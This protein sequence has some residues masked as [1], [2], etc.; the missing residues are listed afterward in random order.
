MES[1]K[2]YLDRKSVEI[3]VWL[4]KKQFQFENNAEQT[5]VNDRNLKYLVDRFY[6]KHQ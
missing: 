1:W 6:Q 4:N 3:S 2:T 5:M